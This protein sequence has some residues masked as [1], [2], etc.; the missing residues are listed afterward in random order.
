MT[1]VCVDALLACDTAGV[2][3]A[4]WGVA[5]RA[6]KGV[7]PALTTSSATIRV[8]DNSLRTLDALALI[9]T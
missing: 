1:D 2:A 5:G 3:V 9:I 7:H 8:S 4:V 6:G